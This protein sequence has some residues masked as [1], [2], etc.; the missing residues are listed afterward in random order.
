M[1]IREK[2][3]TN[4]KTGA[5][6]I[7][8][9]LVKSTREGSKVR[10]EI[11]MELGR[12]EIDRSMWKKL[13]QVLSVRI[14]GSESLFEEDPVL[15]AIADEAMANFSFVD[16]ARS[17]RKAISSQAEYHK[18]DLSSIEASQIRSLGPELIACQRT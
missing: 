5:S 11:V 10:Q 7:K 2:T 3:T 9:Q 18:V 6:Y 14:A 8:H 15:R 1:F 13:A 12:L 17:D 16:I 4:R